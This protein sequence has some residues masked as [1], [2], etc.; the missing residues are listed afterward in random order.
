[1]FD[2]NG[3]PKDFKIPTTMPDGSPFDISKLTNGTANTQQIQMQMDPV[4]QAKRHFDHS[5]KYKGLPSMKP[6]TICVT[7]Y[8][9]PDNLKKALDNLID[10]QENPTLFNILVIDDCSD[11]KDSYDELLKEYEK[12]DYIKY[13]RLNKN[14]GPG[15]ARQTGINNCKT[16]WICFMDDDDFIGKN[17]N[18]II[19]TELY[20][21]NFELIRTPFM[22][23]NGETITPVRE[24]ISYNH[25]KIFNMDMIR[26][27]YIHFPEF[28]V[29]E[30]VYFNLSYFFL[31]EYH[32]KVKDCKDS[33]YGYLENKESITRKQGINFMENNFKDYCRARLEPAKLLLRKYPKSYEVLRVHFMNVIADE[34]L[35][36]QLFKYRKSDRI[37]EYMKL[38]KDDYK[39][40]CKKLKFSG[41]DLSRMIRGNNETYSKVL[42]DFHSRFEFEESEDIHKFISKIV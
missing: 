8:N 30:D 7:T 13:I 31:A 37:D 6:L 1:M 35:F 40:I 3:L 27:Y 20:Q 11:V 26:K 16:R 33:F 18:Y 12:Y 17:I 4:Q 38:V 5:N 36:I 29:F 23:L 34:Y 22:E 10:I 41:D 39:Y 21:D 25:G 42:K 15:V 19:K 32:K 24:D 14:G 9:R 2:A 28:R